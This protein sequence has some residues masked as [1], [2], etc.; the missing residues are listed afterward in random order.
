MYFQALLPTIHLH[1]D[2]ISSEV[3]YCHHSPQI[4]T[5]TR[6]RSLYTT[7]TS[8]LYTHTHARTHTHTHTHTDACTHARTHTR[9][10]AHTD[11]HVNVGLTQTDWCMYPITASPHMAHHHRNRFYF[12]VVHLRCRLKSH[13]GAS[14]SEELYEWAWVR[15]GNVY[16]ICS[17]R[18]RSYYLLH[19]TN[20]VRFL[21]KL[22]NSGY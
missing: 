13:E 6:G 4:N 19:H 20:F 2:V 12:P 21:F 11:A 15:D 17:I 22:F 18:H 3:I 16:S 1:F 5:D 8:I 7:C 14:V 9:T 10:H